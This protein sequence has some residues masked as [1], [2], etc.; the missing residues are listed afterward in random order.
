MP[1]GPTSYFREAAQLTRRMLGA[2]PSNRD[3]IDHISEKRIAAHMTRHAHLNN[4][5][6]KD[7][8]IITARGAQY[9][10]DMMYALTFP[11][12]FRNVQAHYPIVFGKAPDGTF[13][14]LALFGFR[15]KQNLFLDGREMGRA[16]TFR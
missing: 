7:L 3:L 9:G 14:P 1:I 11:A 16:R 12:E 10:D 8:R 4:V 15:E 6:H 13:T 5:E 2:L